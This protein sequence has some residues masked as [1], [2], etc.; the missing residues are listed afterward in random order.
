MVDTCMEVVN[1]GSCTGTP[2]TLILHVTHR[3]I[4]LVVL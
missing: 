4:L 3:L 1:G 2:Q